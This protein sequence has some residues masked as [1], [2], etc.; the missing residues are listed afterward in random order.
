MR[1]RLATPS[2]ATA[3]ARVHVVAWRAAYR[4]HIPDT[5]LD[6]LD[7]AH[8]ATFWQDRIATG[9]GHVFVGELD[10]SVVGF[11]D[12]VP[13]RDKDADSENAAE[14]AAIYV[15]PEHWRKGF[16]RSLFTHTLT[17]AKR[18]NYSWV[19]LWVLTSHSPA[20]MFYERVDFALDGATKTDKMDDAD[21]AQVRYRIAL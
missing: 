6:G 9:R 17:E 8:R 11:C 19:T 10:G 3:I 2:D 13:S 20:R 18:Q 4:G 14:I 5:I 21:L 16:G 12:I 7:V 1:V 15:L